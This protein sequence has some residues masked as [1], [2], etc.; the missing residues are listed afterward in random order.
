MLR[1]RRLSRRTSTSNRSN[2]VEDEDPQCNGESTC[3]M[4]DRPWFACLCDEDFWW[5]EE[6]RY[7]T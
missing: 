3:P 5:D 2:A 7:E 4:C 1:T 6:A